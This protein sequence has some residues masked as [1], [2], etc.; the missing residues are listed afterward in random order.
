MS[1]TFIP[2]HKNIKYGL[3]GIIDHNG[4][5]ID[6]SDEFLISKLGE[7]YQ[8]SVFQKYWDEHHDA[9]QESGV[10]KCADSFVYVEFTILNITKVENGTRIQFSCLVRSDEDDNRRGRISTAR[11][12]WGFAGKY[13][14]IV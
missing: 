4:F 8:E 3:T 13:F 2:L 14:I 12:C 7:K 10:N 9:H 1:T 5:D 6:H 11:H